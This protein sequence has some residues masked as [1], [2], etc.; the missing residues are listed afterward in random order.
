MFL[1]TPTVE[2]LLQSELPDLV[3]M[4]AK[5]TAEYTPLFK[6]EGITPKTAAIKEMIER[7]QAAIDIKKKS[8]K[9]TLAG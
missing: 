2:E 7:I 3:D 8:Q 9:S 4:L 5:Q 1:S 6:K